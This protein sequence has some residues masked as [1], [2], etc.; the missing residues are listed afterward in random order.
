MA[1][2]VFNDGKR[3]AD[4]I[5]PHLHTAQHVALMI[6]RYGEL[7]RIVRRVREIAA[8]VTVHSGRAAGNTND[9]AA[10]RTV[11]LDIRQLS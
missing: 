11:S 7:N 10:P 6:N 2:E 9:A 3:L 1:G 5:Y 8:Q 4:F